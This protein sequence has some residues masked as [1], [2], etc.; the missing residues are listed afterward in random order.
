MPVF[1]K[2]PRCRQSMIEMVGVTWKLIFGNQAFQADM[3]G[4]FSHFIPNQ[5]FSGNIRADFK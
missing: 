4:I 5:A 3:S 2:F 1:Q